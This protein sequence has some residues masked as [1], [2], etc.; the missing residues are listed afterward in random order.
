MTTKYETRDSLGNQYTIIV[1]DDNRVVA[2]NQHRIVTS[3]CSFAHLGA[4]GY[5]EARRQIRDAAR[6]GLAA[7]NR[8]SFYTWTQ[9]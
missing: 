5:A 6:A 2:C 1:R 3:L 4:G 9:A 7:L 8:A